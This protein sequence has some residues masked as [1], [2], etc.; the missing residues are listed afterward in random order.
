MHFDIDFKLFIGGVVCLINS[1]LSFAMRKSPKKI[2]S[3]ISIKSN[4]KTLNL[5]HISLHNM[6]TFRKNLK[7]SKSKTSTTDL[8]EFYPEESTTTK[9]PSSSS[10]NQSPKENFPEN[11]TNEDTFFN[12]LNFN[13]GGFKLNF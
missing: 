1:I 8:K 12:E 3:L 13:G 10:Q 5:T 4:K 9:S 6:K 11:L 2:C 7:S